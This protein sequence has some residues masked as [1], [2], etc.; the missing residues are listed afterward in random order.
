[1]IMGSLELLE[2]QHS[3]LVQ[4]CIQ[5]LVLKEIHFDDKIPWLHSNKLQNRRHPEI[6]KLELKA[7]VS[8]A[9]VVV[10]KT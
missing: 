8:I 5:E 6:S 2:M 7:S 3:T 1:M 10:N 9:D 4:R